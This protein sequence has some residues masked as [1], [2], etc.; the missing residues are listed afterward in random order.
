MAK[1]M[2]GFYNL[3]QCSNDKYSLPVTGSDYSGF[4]NGPAGHYSK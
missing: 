3:V 1:I 2:L 4:V